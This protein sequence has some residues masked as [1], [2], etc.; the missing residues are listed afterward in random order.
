MV[1]PHQIITEHFPHLTEKQITE[2]AKLNG[3]YEKLN[4]MVNLISRKDFENFYTHHVLHSLALAKC[5]DFPAAN[6]VIDIGTGGGFP[7]IPLAI[8]FP[9]VQ[10]FLVD[11]IGKKIR[12]VQ[13]V[14]DILNLQNVTALNSRTEAL[15]IKCDIAVARAVAPMLSLWNWMEGHWLQKPQFYL[16]KGGDLAEEMNELLTEKRGVKFQQFQI[17][18]YFDFPFFET[19]KAI[20]VTGN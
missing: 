4:Q 15:N 11:S 2:F 13:E 12:A 18:D 10:F 19:K 7:G 1:A 3:I 8:M 5:F 6:K 17:S 16:L 20:K 9:E 14:A